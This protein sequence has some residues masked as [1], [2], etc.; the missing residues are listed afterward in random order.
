MDF[1][2]ALTDKLINKRYLIQEKIASGRNIV[3][4]ALDLIRNENIAFKQILIQDKTEFNAVQK[5]YDLLKSINHPNIYRTYDFGKVYSIEPDIT[6]HEIEIYFITFELIQHR[7]FQKSDLEN[8][9]IIKQIFSGLLYLHFNNILHLDIKDENILIDEKSNVKIIDFGLAETS[10]DNKLSNKKGTIEFISPEMI[11]GGLLNFWTDYYSLGIVFYKILFGEFPFSAN[12]ER[13]ILD[14]HLNES[15]KFK[16]SDGIIFNKIISKFLVNNIDQRKENIFKL[17]QEYLGEDLCKNIQLRREYFLSKNQERFLEIIMNKDKNGNINVI[18]GEKGSGKT[19]LL[20]KINK[21]SKSILIN[22]IQINRLDFFEVFL[23]RLKQFK[24]S[25]QILKNDSLSESE[26]VI[27][28]KK[29]I[30]SFSDE[31]NFFIL[32]DDFDK[33]N[34]VKSD[35]LNEILFFALAKGSNLVFTR[36]IGAKTE[37]FY[38]MKIYQI[39]PLMKEDF[40]EYLDKTINK[41]LFNQFPTKFLF[42]YSVHYPSKINDLINRLLKLKRFNIDKSGFSVSN[43]LLLKDV[44]SIADENFLELRGIDYNSK[45]FL[46]FLYIIEEPLDFKRLDKVDNLFEG[47]FKLNKLFQ[48]NLI[49]INEFGIIE[50][51]DYQLLKN[52][53]LDFIIKEKN[54]ITNIIKNLFDV[55]K[56]YLNYQQKVNISSWLMDFEAAYNFIKKAENKLVKEEGY[57]VFLQLIENALIK[58]PEKFKCQLY[59]ISLNPLKEIGNWEKVN[60]ILNYL[61]SDCNIYNFYA[62]KAVTLNKLGESEK[63]IE[64]LTNEFNKDNSNEDI[65]YQLADAY[66]NL[67]KLDNSEKLLN[68]LIKKT[69]DKKLT[70]DSYN[71]LAIVNFY[72]D[73]LKESAIYFNRALE[74][75]KE[76]NLKTK[77]GQILNN[78]GNTLSLLGETEDSYKNWEDS[79]QIA[80]DYGYLELEASNYQNLGIKEFINFNLENSDEKYNQAKKIFEVLGNKLQT[81]QIY[82]NLTEKNILELDYR[83]GELNFKKAFRIFKDINNPLELEYAYILHLFNHLFYRNNNTNSNSK[84]YNIKFKEFYNGIDLSLEKLNSIENIEYLLDIF[85]SNNYNFLFFLLGILI[86]FRFEL[87]SE[88]ILDYYIIESKKQLNFTY[89]NLISDLLSYKTK[90]NKFDILDFE[91]LNKLSD[92]VESKDVSLFSVLVLVEKQKFYKHRGNFDKSRIT[93][94]YIEHILLYVKTTG[95]INKGIFSMYIKDNLVD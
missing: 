16:F 2:K 85:K 21:N 60:K 58:L 91:I 69:K 88:K 76:L 19:S 24:S 26:L 25:F 8:N 71:L 9:D 59:E 35:L 1:E 67:G 22:S 43:E 70:A 11:S 95:I 66:L 40:E 68:I 93:R 61:I 27:E 94:N 13:E 92:F 38:D 77:I 41:Q 90:N 32:I 7:S 62:L 81:G 83:S 79:L 5:E 89:Y 39:T 18:E 57:Y 42:N 4:K 48:N 46:S 53:I 51:I 74:I 49:E 47:E 28:I 6:S 14:W 86:Y 20:E 65:Q 37:V 75:F 34:D 72:Q 10:I 30:N 23:S 45:I 87:I 36:N 17:L 78:L 56:S 31:S 84:I 54:D 82:S 73:K 44:F 63:A 33:I 52:S 3:F 29:E 80:K 12:N 55:S 50:L 15:K 64:I